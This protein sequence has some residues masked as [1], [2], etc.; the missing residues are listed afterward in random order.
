LWPARTGE[1][2]P[3]CAERNRAFER[4]VWQAAVSLA[5]ARSQAAMTTARCLTLNRAQS[6]L[7]SAFAVVIG[8]IA[9]DNLASAAREQLAWILGSVSN[10]VPW[11]KRWLLPPQASSNNCRSGGKMPIRGSRRRPETSPGNRISRLVLRFIRHSGSR[12]NVACPRSIVVCTRGT[13]RAWQCL[14]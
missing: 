2:S 4:G 12:S 11:K 14:Y 5:A 13:N 9:V 6:A 3:L 1:L 7:L 8:I 10:R